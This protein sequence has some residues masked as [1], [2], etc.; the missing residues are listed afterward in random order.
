MVARRALK[1]ELRARVAK[2]G[3]PHR[4]PPGRS[5]L[6]K[7]ATLAAAGAQRWQAIRGAAARRCL[8]G[9]MVLAA[10][11]HHSLDVFDKLDHGQQ[12]VPDVFDD[13]HGLLIV[14]FTYEN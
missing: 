11:D 10:S 4:R 6:S 9:G 8:P 1:R 14:I 12:V 5:L 3:Q 13:L 2:P 7:R